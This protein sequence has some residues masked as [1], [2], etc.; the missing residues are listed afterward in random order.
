VL[1]WPLP[2]SPEEAQSRQGALIAGVQLDE[3][4][5]GTALVTREQYLAWFAE[6]SVPR[7][8]VVDL[9]SG[10]SMFVAERG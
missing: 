10:A 1:D 7:P 6:A 2:S 8:S 5:Q 3:I 9:P 4:Y